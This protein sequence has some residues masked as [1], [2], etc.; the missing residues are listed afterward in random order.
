MAAETR[1]IPLYLLNTKLEDICNKKISKY[2]I[3][4]KI[5]DKEAAA[6]ACAFAAA[7]GQLLSGGVDM[8]ASWQMSVLAAENG[9]ARES[10]EENCLSKS[11]IQAF[12]RIGKACI[13]KWSSETA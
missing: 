2:E 3:L 12:P 4:L 10:P 5:N 1:P 9:I 13:F 11:K 7:C 8:V 6:C